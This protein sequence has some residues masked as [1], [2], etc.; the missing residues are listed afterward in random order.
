MTHLSRK[1]PL[2]P[3]I[4][5]LV[6]AVSSLA[7]RAEGDIRTER[8]HFA[9]GATSAVV[10][11]TITGYQ[12]FDYVLGAS[13]GQSMNVSMATK[14]TA[15]YFNILAPG[16]TEVAF[17]NGSVSE[18]QFEGVLPA[19]GDYKI[20]VYMMRSAARRN[21]KA[22]YRLEMI[23]SGKP[24]AA[25]AAAS[26]ATVR[27]ECP[28]RRHGQG[29]LRAAQGP[30]DGAMRFR[31]DAHWQ[32]RR[33]GGHHHSRTAASGRS[34]SSAAGPPVPTQPR[35]CR[36]QRP[37]RGRPQYDQGR[38]RTLR[39]SGCG[40]R[41]RLTDDCASTD[42]RL[43]IRSVPKQLQWRLHEEVCFPVR[44]PRRDRDERLAVDRARR[45][46]RRDLPGP[47]GRRDEAGNV[48]PLHFFA[49]PGL[50]RP[51]SS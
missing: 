34:S 1:A 47:Q 22:N 37:A 51:R 18:N 11:G 5:A 20:R 35:K 12:T 6:S 45:F 26:T 17:F 31:R 28:L 2:A 14:N 49:A 43:T 16:E 4:L 19:T 23:V 50:H 7:A 8:V 40:S 33:H 36:I 3:M 32:R 46:R 24:Q 29:A 30:A 41:R 21:E 42:V 10:E 38:R 48:W 44:V 13:K 25:A 39:D 15:T 27:K 9:K